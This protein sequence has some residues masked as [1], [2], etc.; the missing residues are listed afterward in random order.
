MSELSCVELSGG[1]YLIDTE[2]EVPGL[3]GWLSSR[4]YDH[5]LRGGDV[6]YLSSCSDGAL[7]RVSLA[8]VSGHGTD[9]S[10]VAQRLR[11][12]MRAHIETEDHNLVLQALN[13]EFGEAGGEGLFA[14]ALLLSY[15]RRSGHLVYSIAGH[16]MPLWYSTVEGNWRFLQADDSCD[17]HGTPNLPLGLLGGTNYCQAYIRVAPGDRIILYTDGVVEAKNLHRQTLGF[18]GLAE[19]ATGISQDDEPEAVSRFIHDR[20]NRFRNGAPAD[21]DVTLLVLQRI[22]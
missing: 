4:P 5:A 12:M 19:I 13:E 2:I 6:F 16:P 11:D 3:R 21:D 15:Y 8:D 9:V 7:T 20:I 10:Q 14:T 17:D 1:N 22:D 18:L